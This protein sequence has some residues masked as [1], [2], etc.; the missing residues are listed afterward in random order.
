[1]PKAL[2]LADG[3]TRTTFC[4]CDEEWDS[5]KH[6]ASALRPLLAL[7]ASISG[8]FVWESRRNN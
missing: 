3:S 4:G 2:T 6:S 1:M 5:S 8:G 7:C